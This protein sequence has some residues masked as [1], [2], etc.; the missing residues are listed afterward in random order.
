MMSSKSPIRFSPVRSV[1]SRR[2]CHPAYPSNNAGLSVCPDSRKRG[3]QWAWK[4]VLA[5]LER[6]DW[7]VERRISIGKRYDEFPGERDG[8]AGRI[9]VRPERRSVHAH[10][11]IL[12]DGRHRIQSALKA[13]SI[14]AAIHYPAP[15]ES[16]AGLRSGKRIPR[17]GKP[18][19]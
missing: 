6:F 4:M 9:N 18:G 16:V 2:V 17:G 14:L 5:K 8:R 11:T 12:L 15:R 13:C 10:Y 19:P 1:L 7:E 3:N